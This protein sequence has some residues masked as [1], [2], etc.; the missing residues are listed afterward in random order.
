ML[1][2][3]T[4]LLITIALGVLVLHITIG[5]RYRRF[6]SVIEP[7]VLVDLYGRIDNSLKA[8]Y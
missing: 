4:D 3:V 6:R 5:H 1:S 8:E 7:R 2:A